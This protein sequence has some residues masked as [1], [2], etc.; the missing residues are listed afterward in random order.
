MATVEVRVVAAFLCP[1]CQGIL[2]PVERLYK[3]GF[4]LVID[5]QC[6]DGFVQD[7]F[8]HAIGWTRVRLV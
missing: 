6:K 7:R 4:R 1:H 5:H 3:D 2:V 8:E